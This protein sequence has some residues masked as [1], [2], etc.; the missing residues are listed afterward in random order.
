MDKDN[1]Q[2]QA[3]GS[4]Q[5]DG[6]RFFSQRAKGRVGNLLNGRLDLFDAASLVS[7]LVQF[8]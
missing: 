8:R 5:L 1:G 2:K 3:T 6:L 7:T 4:A